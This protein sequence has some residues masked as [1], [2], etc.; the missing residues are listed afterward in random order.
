MTQ[1]RS[2]HRKPRRRRTRNSRYARVLR[3]PVAVA[4]AR[5]SR[6]SMQSVRRSTGLAT[7]A[8]R[9]RQTS[10]VAQEKGR[11]REK[12]SFRRLAARADLTDIKALYGEFIDGQWVGDDHT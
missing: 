9:M 12:G 4:S 10:R 7:D 1:S 6:C 11:K 5:R 8:M 3:S 2:R